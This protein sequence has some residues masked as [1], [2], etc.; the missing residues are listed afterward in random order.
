MYSCTYR[1]RLSG[2]DSNFKS[3][4]SSTTRQM[5]ALLVF[6]KV[7]SI[8][9]HSIR[10]GK[11]DLSLDHVVSIGRREINARQARSI[12]TALTFTMENF[13]FALFIESTPEQKIV[14]HSIDPSIMH[15]HTPQ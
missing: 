14:H 10:G 9:E 13:T 3:C 7:R 8:Q 15:T 6:A 1:C 4:T 5:L 2:F 11:T 12:L